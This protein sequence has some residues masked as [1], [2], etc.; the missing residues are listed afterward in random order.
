[1]RIKASDLAERYSDAQR[2]LATV[3][4]CLMCTRDENVKL[5]ELLAIAEGKNESA[6]TEIKSLKEV[7]KS[8]TSSNFVMKE[9]FEAVVSTLRTESKAAVDAAEHRIACMQMEIDDMLLNSRPQTDNSGSLDKYKQKAQAALSKVRP[10]FDCSLI[11][12]MC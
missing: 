11:R 9:K 4:E 6:V 5:K 1:M 2:E 7:V 3:S 12:R 10:A 8:T